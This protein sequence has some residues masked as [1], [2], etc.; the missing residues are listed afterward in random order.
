MSKITAYTKADLI[1]ER[2]SPNLCENYHTLNHKIRNNTVELAALV[3]QRLP[4]L[5]HT[6][7][8][9]LRIANIE[10]T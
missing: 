5:A 7:F 8:A 4:T 3:V 10:Q 1:L 9:W 2:K 6:L